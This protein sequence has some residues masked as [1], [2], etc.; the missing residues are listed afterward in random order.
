MSSFALNFKFDP[1]MEALLDEATRQK[2]EITVQM[3]DQLLKRTEQLRA[4]LKSLSDYLAERSV[5][6]DDGN[7]SAAV[8]TQLLFLYD[9]HYQ[10]DRV[11]RTLGLFA[12]NVRET[13]D[14]F[15]DWELPKEQ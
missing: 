13:V 10:A 3:C 12:A 5:M 9:K 6:E 11:L 2:I 4:S 15:C 7:V 8:R 1:A 14:D